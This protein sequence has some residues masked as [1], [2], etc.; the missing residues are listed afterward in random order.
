MLR[1][2]SSLFSLRVYGSKFKNRSFKWFS[3]SQNCVGIISAGSTK[4]E[5]QQEALNIFQ[6]WLN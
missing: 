2:L 3:N 4:L 1:E 6:L 5:L